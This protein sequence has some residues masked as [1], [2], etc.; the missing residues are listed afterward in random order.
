MSTE[1]HT[2]FG[3]LVN[4]LMSWRVDTSGDQKN[5]WMHKDNLRLLMS[6][7]GLYTVVEWLEYHKD[8]NYAR[9]F[10]SKFQ[11]LYKN[12][13]DFYD[14]LVQGKLNEERERDERIQLLEDEAQQLA[15]H[16]SNAQCLCLTDKTI[17]QRIIGN[18][19]VR[20]LEQTGDEAATRK[21]SEAEKKKG[22]FRRLF[23]IIGAVVAFFAALLTCLYYLGWLEPIKLFIRSLFARAG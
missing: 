18:K 21:H 22:S 7:S 2:L 3:E 17:M 1:E 19:G 5:L 16:V 8:P 4:A 13:D 23:G 14:K 6:N 9:E 20:E 11:N 15:Q 10:E 12:V